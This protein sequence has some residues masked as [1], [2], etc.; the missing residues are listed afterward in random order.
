MKSIIK[1]MN[2]SP[3]HL[4][5]SYIAPNVTSRVC[6]FLNKES[7][8]PVAFMQYRDKDNNSSSVNAFR[9]LV[10][11]YVAETVQLWW[12]C[13]CKEIEKFVSKMNNDEL[14]NMFNYESI[15]STVFIPAYIKIVDTNNSS[16]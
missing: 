16:R 3:A 10:K 13:R 11:K 12:K 5:V 2:Q 14:K 7:K 15:N 8:D 6:V 4:I 9:H 1:R